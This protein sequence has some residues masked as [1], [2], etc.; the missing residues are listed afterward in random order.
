MFASR[1]RCSV[2][3]I[4]IELIENTTQYLFNKYPHFELM[5]H[6]YYDSIHM[7]RRSLLMNYYTYHV[8]SSEYIV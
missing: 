5:I 3:W 2:F 6:K 7:Q 8:S 1:T 4:L